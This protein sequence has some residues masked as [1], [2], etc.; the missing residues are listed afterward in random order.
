[1]LNVHLDRLLAS[2]SFAGLVSALF[3]CSLLLFF[4]FVLVAVRASYRY[5]L[6]GDP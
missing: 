2:L 5:R 1:M 6:N 4:F 3:F